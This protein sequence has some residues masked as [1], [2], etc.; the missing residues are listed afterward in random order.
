MTMPLHLPICH[1]L[2]KAIREEFGDLKIA[3]GG[4]AFRFTN[5]LWKKWDV[6][7]YAEN[8]EQTV[9]WAEEHIIH[10]GGLAS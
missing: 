1:D 9:D 3:V 5:Q 4:R 10:K 8:A 7:V 2:V 6:D